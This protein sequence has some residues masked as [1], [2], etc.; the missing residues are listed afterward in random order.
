MIEF[1]MWAVV[2]ILLIAFGVFA[3]S[4]VS[5]AVQI[6]KARIMEQDRHEIKNLKYP[7]E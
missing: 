1:V 2:M 7:T 6:A 3:V 4:L 5:A